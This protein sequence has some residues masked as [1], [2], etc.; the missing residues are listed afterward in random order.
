MGQSGGQ[1]VGGGADKNAPSFSA[2]QGQGHCLQEVRASYASPAQCASWD[3]LLLVAMG[4][5][6]FHAT[7]MFPVPEENGRTINQGSQGTR[8]H[9]QLSRWL[10]CTALRDR[11]RVTERFI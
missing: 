7:T 8:D 1:Q 6:Q 10:C 5:R 3:V 4:L 11:F 9:P 2:F